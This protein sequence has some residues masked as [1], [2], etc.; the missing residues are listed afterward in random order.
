MFLVDLMLFPRLVIRNG[1]A[2]KMPIHVNLC[3]NKYLQN[4]V[5]VCLFLHYYFLYNNVKILKI[6]KITQSHIYIY[7]FIASIFILGWC[8]TKCGFALLNFAI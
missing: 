5:E 1:R 8:K 4:L 6:Q 2:I 3:V 7:N